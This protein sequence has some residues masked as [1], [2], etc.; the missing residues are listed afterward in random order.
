[1]F[2]DDEDDVTD[3]GLDIPIE[4]PSTSAS[5]VNYDGANTVE[6]DTVTTS[7]KKKGTREH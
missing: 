1:M 5:S 6:E 2:D 3:E 4:I 7:S